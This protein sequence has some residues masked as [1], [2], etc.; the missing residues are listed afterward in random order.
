MS[1]ATKKVSVLTNN[2]ELPGKMYFLCSMVSPTGNQKHKVQAFKFHDVC[3]DEQEIKYLQKYYHDLDPDFDVYVGTI[4]KWMP[5]VF[6]AN[7]VPNSE[8]ADERLNEIIAAHRQT[9]R[10]DN[11]EFE[12]RINKHVKQMEHTA[13]KEGQREKVEKEKESC[14]QMLYRIK[15][16]ELVVERRRQELDALN[17]LYL[18]LYTKQ[19]QEDASKVTFPPLTEP[20]LMYYNNYTEEPTTEPT[21]Q[22][23]TDIHFL[24]T[25]DSDD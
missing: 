13:S 23:K 2:P 3:G 14:V 1:S 11:M 4:G 15:Q 22:D 18:E 17:E 6:D 10:T 5:W 20:S 9:K 8:Y 21:D 16:L 19:E 7:D 25:V 12:N 24:T